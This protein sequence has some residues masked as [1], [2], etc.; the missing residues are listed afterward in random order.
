M[1]LSPDLLSL[2]RTLADEAECDCS[3][4]RLSSLAGCLESVAREIRETVD[5]ASAPAPTQADLAAIL[6]QLK[7]EVA[8]SIGS[9]IARGGRRAQPFT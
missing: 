8:A 5:A 2:L 7:R 1:K 6:P 9:A 3:P 4:I